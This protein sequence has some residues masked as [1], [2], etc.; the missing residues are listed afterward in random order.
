MSAETRPGLREM[1]R[2][3]RAAVVGD[4][5]P[6]D[7]EALLSPGLPPHVSPARRL[8]VH[9]NTYFGALTETLAAAFPTTERLVGARFFAAV[10]RAFIDASPPRLPVLAHYGDGFPDFLDRFPPAGGFPWLAD[11]A[12]LEWAATAA[13]FAADATPLNPATLA[14]ALTTPE[15]VGALTF[16]RHPAASLIASPWAVYGVWAAHRSDPPT[17]FDPAAGA[18]NVLVSRPDDQTS[19]RPLTAGEAA[20][21]AA[22]FDGSDLATAAGAGSAVDAGL[23]L[24]NIL[25]VLLTAGAFTEP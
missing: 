4:A 15:Q 11:V 6:G 3:F 8:A 22:L 1:Q 21:A 25:G 10:A 16:R 12:R 13:A 23:D 5:A 9:R 18:E 24:Q 14:A 17:P 7:A 20:F 2:R 19:V